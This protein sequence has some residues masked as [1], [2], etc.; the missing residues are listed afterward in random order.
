MWYDHRNNE[1]QDFLV[2]SRSNVFSHANTVGPVPFL[3][4]GTWLHQEHG[5]P[6]TRGFL[7]TLFMAFGIFSVSTGAA[8]YFFPRGTGGRQPD[9]LEGGSF[10]E[11]GGDGYTTDACT[12]DL[13]KPAMKGADVVSYH[14]LEPGN[15]AMYGSAEYQ[16]IYHDYTFMFVSAENKAL[17]DVR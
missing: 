1:E 6:T 17:F 10:A 3:T 15:A 5:R 7:L 13:T 11:R 14:T 8:R 9:L 4:P 2:P 16:S 12:G